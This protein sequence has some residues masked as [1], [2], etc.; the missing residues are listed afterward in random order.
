MKTQARLRSASALRT[1]FLKMRKESHLQ[2]QQQQQPAST[3]DGGGGGDARADD[4]A[5]PPASSSSVPSTFRGAF[6]HWDPF[7]TGR[8]GR[9]R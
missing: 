3:R 7:R 5:S 9:G 4:L 1:M 6:T 8:G 2:Q